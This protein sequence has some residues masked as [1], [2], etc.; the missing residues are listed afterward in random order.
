M[1]YYLETLCV[2]GGFCIAYYYEEFKDELP[3]KSYDLIG[4]MKDFN[5]YGDILPPLISLK[6]GLLAEIC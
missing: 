3:Y 6:W 1:L 4:V 2:T 5:V